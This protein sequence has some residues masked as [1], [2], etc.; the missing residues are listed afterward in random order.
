MIIINLSDLSRDVL[1]IL[2]LTSCVISHGGND[3]PLELRPFGQL[4][5][6]KNVQEIFLLPSTL[7]ILEIRKMPR[8][9]GKMRASVTRQLGH[10]SVTL[11]KKNILIQ[12]I[13]WQ[14]S[15]SADYQKFFEKANSFYLKKMQRTDIFNVKYL[16]S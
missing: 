16:S 9:K 5:P 10:S 4:R 13:L 12:N 7:N 15:F 6:V 3:A 11:E 14:R 2:R 8:T 1:C